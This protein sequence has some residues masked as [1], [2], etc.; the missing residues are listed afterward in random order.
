MMLPFL[1]FSA[2]LKEKY[3]YL[4]SQTQHIVFSI[5]GYSINVIIIICDSHKIIGTEYFIN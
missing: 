5:P 2:D 1:G 3:N 4:S